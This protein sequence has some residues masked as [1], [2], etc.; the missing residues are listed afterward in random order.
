[1][2]FGSKFFFYSFTSI[3]FR[4]YIGFVIFSCVFSIWFLD[5]GIY[6][7]GYFHADKQKLYC[8][9]GGIGFKNKAWQSAQLVRTSRYR[10]IKRVPCLVVA[11]SEFACRAV[12]VVLSKTLVLWL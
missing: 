8:S 10:D 5:R 1:M 4:L 12:A 6:V 3:Q 7:A 2:P 11:A 9:I